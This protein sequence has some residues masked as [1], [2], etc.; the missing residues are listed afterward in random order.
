[1]AEESDDVV[2]DYV[3]YS[4][5]VATTHYYTGSNLGH[6]A[7]T[8]YYTVSYLGHTDRDWSCFKLFGLY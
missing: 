6:V 5:H 4:R 8:H 3:S 1:M 7:T 2:H